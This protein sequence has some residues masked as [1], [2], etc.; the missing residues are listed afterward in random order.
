MLRID[1]CVCVG[2]TFAELLLRA[3]ASGLDRAGLERETGCGSRCGLCG[4]YIDEML[5]TG[6]TVF[7]ELLIEGRASGR[8]P[9]RRRPINS[10][11]SGA[12]TRG[13]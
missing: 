13:S 1:R 8:K 11:R 2:C 9:P 3:R 12:P 10:D 5:R 7:H 6:Q 4:P